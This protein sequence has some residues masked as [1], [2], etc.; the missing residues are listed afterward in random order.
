MHLS[1]EQLNEYLDGALTPE[2]RTEAVKHFAVCADCA[3]RL[4][5]Q[6]ALFAQIESLPE[7][8]LSRDL[9]GSLVRALRHGFASQRGEILPR[10]V[11]LTTGLQAVLAILALAL[12]APLLNE[13]VGPWVAEYKLPSL[14]RLLVQMQTQWALWLASVSEFALPP[15]PDFELDISSLALTVTAISAFLIWLVGNGLLLR[16][17]TRSS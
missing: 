6:Q 4:T 9:A 12:A 13:Y 3:T 14:T 8:A 16:R 1:D 17:T 11:R 2:A 10:W 7:E 15:V 5:A